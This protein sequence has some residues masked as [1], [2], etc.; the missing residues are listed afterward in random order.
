MR[1]LDLTGRVFGRL[2]AVRRLL[3][4]YC[5]EGPVYWACCCRCGEY[6]L[7]KTDHLVSGRTRSCGCLNSEATAQRSTKHGAARRGRMSRAYES[8]RAAKQ[9]CTD[10][11]HHAYKNYGGRG[12]EFRF[13]SFEQFFAELGPRPKGKSVDRIDN[14]GHYEPG[15]VRW[16]TRL[17]QAHNRRPRAKKVGK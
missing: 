15:N 8:Y 17:E 6:A 16:A 10:T 3:R 1:G 9:R 13:T 4:K 11:N 12:I 2:T 14:N 7:V 5:P